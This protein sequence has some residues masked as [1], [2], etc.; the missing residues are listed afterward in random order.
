MTASEWGKRITNTMN[1]ASSYVGELL[2][3]YEACEKERDEH[4]GVAIAC[5]ARAEKAEARVKVL[6]EALGRLLD[7]SEYYGAEQGTAN[8][9]C[10]N[11]QP[12]TME[13]GIELLDSLVQ[14]RAALAGKEEEPVCTCAPEWPLAGHAPGCGKEERDG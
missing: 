5:E 6:E 3:D 9:R 14:A 10:G 7:A 13:E 2:S 11:A 12:I 4:K 8:A 1:S